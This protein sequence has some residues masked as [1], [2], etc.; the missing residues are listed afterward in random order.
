[1]TKDPGRHGSAYW[2][3][4]KIVLE[5]ATHCAICRRPLDFNAPP[6]SRWAPSVDHIIP[7]ATLKH[8]EPAER[9]RLATDPANM[10][11]AH[12]TC[13]SSR[14]ARSGNASRRQPQPRAQTRSI[15]EIHDLNVIVA[16][17]RAEE[18]AKN[19]PP[20]GMHPNAVSIWDTPW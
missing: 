6:R 1:M 16:K 8:Y 12:V 7:L 10:R 2:K 19:P 20:P 14:G 5:G 18:R 4:R 9:R 3:A 11:P 15:P 17:L 13:N